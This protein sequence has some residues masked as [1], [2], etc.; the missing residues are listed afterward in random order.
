MVGRQTYGY[1]R[2]VLDSGLT[3]SGNCDQFIFAQ[4]FRDPNDLT[5]V[6]DQVHPGQE[7]AVVLEEQQVLEF[8][9][10]DPRE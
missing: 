4:M 3:I 2:V 7:I 9:L 10:D 6:L 1:L 5:K 8:L